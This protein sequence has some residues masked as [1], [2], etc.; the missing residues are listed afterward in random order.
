VKSGGPILEFHLEVSQDSKTC[1]GR[2]I[3]RIDRRRLIEK[4]SRIDKSLFQESEEGIRIVP[5]I[6][7]LT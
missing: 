5:G 2:S 4:I 7:K 6:K 1:P 3:T